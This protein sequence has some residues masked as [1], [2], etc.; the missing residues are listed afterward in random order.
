MR[1]FA[2]PTA[3]EMKR[4]WMITGIAI[5]VGAMAG[6]A[7]WHFHGCTNGCAITSSPVNSTLYGGLMGGLLLNTFRKEKKGEEVRR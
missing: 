5:A 7:Y 2:P 4:T 3:S 1:I 6:W